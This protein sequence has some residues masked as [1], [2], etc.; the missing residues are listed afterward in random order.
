MPADRGGIVRDRAADVAPWHPGRCAAVVL[1][2]TDVVL[3]DL[4]A[5]PAWLDA[6]VGARS[7]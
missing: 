7:A 1:P 5:F 4:T 6:Q 2:G 3:D